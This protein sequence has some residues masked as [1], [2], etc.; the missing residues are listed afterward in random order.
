VVEWFDADK[1]YG[2]V[3]ASADGVQLLVHHKQ[4]AGAGYITHPVAG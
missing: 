4:I 2:F 1:G 3:A